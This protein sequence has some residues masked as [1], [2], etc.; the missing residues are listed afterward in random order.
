ME[1]RLVSL[2]Y[3][4][5]TKT[6]TTGRE[7]SPPQHRHVEYP[8]NNVPPAQVFK[9]P[10][11]HQN[12]PVKLNP[13]LNSHP[14]NQVDRLPP[15]E[16]IHASPPVTTEKRHAPEYFRQPFHPPAH[17]HDPIPSPHH[18]QNHEHHAPD[19]RNSVDQSRKLSFPGHALHER[20]S[21]FNDAIGRRPA[22][23]NL[24]ENSTP[25]NGAIAIDES[26]INRYFP[27]VTI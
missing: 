22:N 3:S 2:E 24:H 14:R 13:V 16:A 25:S 11:P 21:S 10:H 19:R 27:A 5:Q 7:H 1:D 23:L 9:Q 26:A 8:N 17:R 4:V 15:I 18:Y 20:S 6:H 12:E